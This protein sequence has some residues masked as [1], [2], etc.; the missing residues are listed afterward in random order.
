[1]VERSY[2]DVD[3]VQEALSKDVPSVSDI[4]RLLRL[5]DV[6]V[7]GAHA[8]RLR[9]RI[10]GRITTFIPNMILNYTNV[11]AIRCKF[12]AFWRSKGDPDSYVLSVKDAL[13]MIESVE[14]RF[15]PIRQVLIQGGVNHDIG[16]EYIEDL[17]RS[18]RR[19]FP[20]ISIHGL[21]PPEV[22]Y[23]SV[24]ERMSY[25]EVL[26]RLKEAGL[27]SMPGGG[28][29]IL[30]DGV[31][32]TISPHKIDSETW[33]KVMETAHELGMPTSAT[34]VYGHLESTY[35]IALHLKRILDLQLR[36]RGFNAFVAWNFEP[37]NTPLERYGIVRYART[38]YTLLKIVSV[39]RIVF[40]HYVPNIQSSWLTNGVEMAQL[41]LLYGANDFGGTLYE[42]RVMPAAG[43]R[44]KFMTRGEVVEIIRSVG[45]IPAERDGLYRIVEVYD[46]S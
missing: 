19:R 3:V 6:H 31:R 46:D 18:I 36:T 23:L 8:H 7:L 11:C 13:K 26:E 33:I 30:A 40:K 27:D 10:H 32:R 2:G 16:I 41:S 34:M 25:R 20:H 22:H 45:L 29:E 24:R 21:S 43:V 37:K 9:L 35:E 5:D 17:F 28:A 39:A 38:G 14:S 15:G 44:P 12:C 42:E 1:M 4:E